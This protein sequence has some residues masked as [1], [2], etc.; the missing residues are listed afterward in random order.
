[1]INFPLYKISDEH[2]NE[3]LTEDPAIVKMLVLELLEDN[4]IIE[5]RREDNERI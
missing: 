5:I 2:N 1:M 4:D 3:I